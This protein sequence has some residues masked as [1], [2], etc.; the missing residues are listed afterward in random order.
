MIRLRSQGCIIANWL[1]ILQ[2]RNLLMQVQNFVYWRN[3][4][5]VMLFFHTPRQESRL[6]DRCQ[7][8]LIFFPIVTLWTVKGGEKHW[9]H[10]GR[11][12]WSLPNKHTISFA[13]KLSFQQKAIACGLTCL[14]PVIFLKDERKGYKKRKLTADV[15]NRLWP[16]IHCC[17]TF[18]QTFAFII[19]PCIVKGT[20]FHWASVGL[21]GRLL[22]YFNPVW[23][24]L[25]VSFVRYNRQFTAPPCTL[26][27]YHSQCVAFTSRLAISTRPISHRAH[28]HNSL[29]TAFTWCLVISI[30]TQKTVFRLQ[31]QGLLCLKVYRPYGKLAMCTA[32]VF[33]NFLLHNSVFKVF[34]MCD[35]RIHCWFYSHMECIVSQSRFLG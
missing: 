17:L 19:I 14:Y 9:S 18:E 2:Q 24:R 4:Y 20:W 26:V 35:F 15:F 21:K 13:L 33:H 11:L 30:T 3:L 29:Y 34:S 10:S 32:Y 5:T 12:K 7:G 27:I 23:S 22:N 31:P 1:L 28:L 6:L 8:N 16:K 25:S